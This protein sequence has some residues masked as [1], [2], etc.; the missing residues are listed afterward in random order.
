MLQRKKV[1]TETKET[2][3][4]R[5]GVTSEQRKIIRSKLQSF[6]DELTDELKLTKEALVQEI[7]YFQQSTKNGRTNPTK[8]QRVKSLKYHRNKC[9][10]PG[11]DKT[12][13]VKTA[14][15]HHIKRGISGLHE[16]ENMIPYCDEHHNKHHGSL[17]SLTKGSR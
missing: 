11:C 8:T 15:F 13:T 6:V 17:T 9:S 5:S 14:V 7:R 12:L 10:H 16:P 2:K 4:F 3:I 1:M